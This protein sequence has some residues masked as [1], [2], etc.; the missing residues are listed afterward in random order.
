MQFAKQN[1]RSSGSVERDSRCPSCNLG[2]ADGRRERDR[3]KADYS[4][5][6]SAIRDETQIGTCACSPSRGSRGVTLLLF[7]CAKTVS[8]AHLFQLPGLPFERK[9]IPQIVVIVRIQRK[10]MEPLEQTLV[11]WAQ[12]VGRSN[13]PAPTNRINKIGP[14]RLRRASPSA[15][16]PTA[17]GSP[18]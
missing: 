13:R 7:S 4:L 3:R 18:R 16:F 11:P 14:I 10:T 1:G 8:E 6:V 12:G 15:V 17:P 9:Q 5:A 2:S